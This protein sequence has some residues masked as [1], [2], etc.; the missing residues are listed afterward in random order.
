VPRAGVAVSKS[1]ESER[2]EQSPKD[3]KPKPAN[4]TTK[5]EGREQSP[6]DP[7]PKPAN[8]TTENQ[9]DGGGGGNV[10]QTGTPEKFNGK[11]WSAD[12]KPES[13]V[14]ILPNEVVIKKEFRDKPIE[15]KAIHNHKVVVRI[16]IAG[17]PVFHDTGFVQFKL[18]YDMTV[19]GVNETY[20]VEWIISTSGHGSYERGTRDW[21]AS[22]N[23]VKKALVISGGTVKLGPSPYFEYSDIQMKALEIKGIDEPDDKSAKPDDPK[24][25][26][27]VKLR[28]VA[29]KGEGTVMDVSG[30]PHHL[31]GGD[32]RAVVIG[33]KLPLH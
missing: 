31:K 29:I 16:A 32:E 17:K 13:A 6:K 10:H 25:W 19:D 15:I 28:V 8:T 1:G 9:S 14:D 20:I 23:S 24:S 11:A 4:T 3:P 5:S 27:L 12:I 33:F 30:K 2:R 26:S 21:G 18:R 7:K 22:A